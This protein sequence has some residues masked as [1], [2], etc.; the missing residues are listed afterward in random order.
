MSGT[1]TL[2]KHLGMISNLGMNLSWLISV[3][4][5]NFVTFSAIFAVISSDW[6]RVDFQA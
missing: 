5:C 4:I 2:V 1:V 6:L 3:T